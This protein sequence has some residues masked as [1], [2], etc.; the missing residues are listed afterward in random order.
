ML[1]VNL[2]T[3]SSRTFSM[4]MQLLSQLVDPMTSRVFQVPKNMKSI[5]VA[6]F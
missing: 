6:V 2:K 4:A 1:K 5:R 3:T